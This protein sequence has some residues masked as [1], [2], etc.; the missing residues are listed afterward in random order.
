MAEEYTKAIRQSI[1]ESVLSD[2]SRIQDIDCTLDNLSRTFAGMCRD[3]VRFLED[4]SCFCIY[5]GKRWVVDGRNNHRTH[6]LVQ[7]FIATGREWFSCAAGFDDEKRKFFAKY[8]ARG[9]REQLVK[10][11]MGKDVILCKSSDFDK[12]KNLLNVQNGTL[13]LDTGE[14]KPHNPDDLMMMIAN[15][16]Y[17]P[18]AKAERFVKFMNEIMQGNTVM[19]DHL[20]EVLGYALSGYTDQERFFI[21]YGETTRNGK[22]T[23]DGAILGVLGD[24]GKSARYES[25]QE[26]YYRNSGGSPSEDIARLQGARY[27]SVPEP[28]N[29]MVLD[30]ARVKT[31]TGG[32]TI[33]ARYLH[34]G[35]FEYK[36]SF[37]IFISTN[38]LP[39]ITDDTLFKSDRVEVILFGKHFGLDER[40]NTLKDVLSSEEEKS[41]ILNW[42]IEGYQRVRKARYLPMPKEVQYA[43]QM[44]QAENDKIAEFLSDEMEAN[45]EAKTS[46]KDVYARFQTW[47]RESG[48]QAMG[49]QKFK[50]K[51]QDKGLW[52]FVNGQNWV[53]G[54]QFKED[55]K[56][57]PF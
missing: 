55:V 9:Q 26:S 8:D 23:L 41:G 47:C 7:T 43:N 1:V 39:T 4:R 46:Q 35:S 45:A 18:N 27:V 30:V 6:E 3:R 24:Y 38:H 48:Y 13:N 20:Q 42:M 5:D 11:L 40:D 32:D 33:N 10:D 25:F 29:T 56:N 22:G 52:L 15:V 50:K 57:N 34:Q 51:L 36:P 37:K 16:T 14:L 2:H 49:K 12:Q 19:V 54:Y 17:N 53:A 21:L 28:S 31:L 44:Y